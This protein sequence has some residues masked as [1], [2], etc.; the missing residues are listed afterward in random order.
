[1][2]SFLVCSVIMMVLLVLK[3]YKILANKYH[4]KYR[5][6]VDSVVHITF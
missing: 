2:K 3:N 4:S 5:Q 6:N 1:M